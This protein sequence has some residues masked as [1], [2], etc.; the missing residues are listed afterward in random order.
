MVSV[1]CGA[2]VTERVVVASTPP[3][4]SRLWARI[5][6][7]PGISPVSEPDQSVTPDAT[8]HAL[9]PEVFSSRY[10]TEVAPLLGSVVPA[11]VMSAVRLRAGAAG[12]VME[13]G[14]GGA[15]MTTQ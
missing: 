2:Y 12:V 13:S 1:P 15:V 8:C 9:V 3:P 4:E 10:C 7:Y 11:T 6:L 14:C 5:T